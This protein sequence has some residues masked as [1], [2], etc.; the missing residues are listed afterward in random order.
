MNFTSSTCNDTMGYGKFVLPEYQYACDS[1][2]H[3]NKEDPCCNVTVNDPK[4]KEHV[5]DEA[6]KS[7]MSGHSSFSFYCATFLVIYL[8]ARFS[9]DQ[10]QDATLIKEGATVPRRL[11]RWIFIFLFKNISLY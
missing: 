5:L 4:G 10:A 9:N 2:N 1:D 3:K 8:H 6:R 11:L 7:F